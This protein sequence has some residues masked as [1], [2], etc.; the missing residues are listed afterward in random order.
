MGEFNKKYPNLF[1]FEDEDGNVEGEESTDEEDVE[2]SDSEDN[3]ITQ[4]NKRWGFFSWAIQVKEVKSITLDEVYD[5][6]IIEF[7]NI[8]CYIKDKAELDRK[9][10]EDYLKKIKNRR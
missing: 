5:I 7:L 10:Q 8:M 9:Q 1:G 6:N 2:G 3:Y 4:F